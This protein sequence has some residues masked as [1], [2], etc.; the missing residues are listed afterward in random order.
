MH[1][2]HGDFP[3]DRSQRIVIAFINQIQLSRV[4]C[5]SKQSVRATAEGEGRGGREASHISTVSFISVG[6][7]EAEWLS[8]V[9]ATLQ[10]SSQKVLL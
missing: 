5:R 3:H 6:L 4:A 8:D 9:T 10:E 7:K 1:V 2:T